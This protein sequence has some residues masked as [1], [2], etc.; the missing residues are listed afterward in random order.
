MKKVKL[1]LAAT[2]LS[3]IFFAS[4]EKTDSLTV[5]SVA[6]KYVGTLSSDSGLKNT[7]GIASGEFDATVDV[8]DTGDGQIEVHCYGGDIDTTFMLNYYGNGD[9]TMVCLD[10]DAFEQMYGHIMGDDH[11]STGNMGQGGMMGSTGNMGGQ[12]NWGD[13]MSGEHQE[14]DEHFG[15]F[16]MTNNTFDY[17]MQTG[18]GDLRFQG[19]KTD[20]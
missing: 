6:G 17:T 14:G 8:T 13:H 19:A 7:D 12:M 18:T 15:G 5:D 3:T 2:V 10:G 20:M 1:L 16:D 4:C 11:G 9:S